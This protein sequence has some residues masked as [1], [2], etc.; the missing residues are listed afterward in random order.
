MRTKAPITNPVRRIYMS[1][2]KWTRL[3]RSFTLP[4]LFLL[5]AIHHSFSCTARPFHHFFISGIATWI[6]TCPSF[7]LS[8][9]ASLLT[10][11][12][13]SKLRADTKTQSSAYRL[14]SC[15]QAQLSRASFSILSALTRNLLISSSN[16]NPSPVQDVWPARPISRLHHRQPEE[17]QA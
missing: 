15:L 5:P 2:E 13:I 12:S 4:A 1:R 10:K 3:S 14:T 17:G 6:A 11:H 9:V 7:F 8:Q 16:F